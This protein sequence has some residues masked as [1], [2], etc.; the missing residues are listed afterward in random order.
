M[1]IKALVLTTSLTRYVGDYL[2]N[3]IYE[4]IK[5]LKIKGN[6]ELDIV[7]PDTI[8]SIKNEKRDD[9]NIY[10]F[11]YVFPRRLQK[12]AY[13]SGIAINLKNNPL[14][15]LQVPSFGL[16]FLYKSL[17]VYNNHNIIY[18]QLVFAGMI[19]IILR[20]IL[21]KKIPI[22]ITFWGKDVDNLAKH[23]RIYNLLIKEGD[24]FITLSPDMSKD[25]LKIGCDKL[26]VK[27]INIG[28]NLSNFN[29]RKPKKSKKITFLF[30][31]RLI[32]KK[33]I[34]YMIN[35][36]NKILKNNNFEL[37]ILGDGSL[38]DSL[39]LQVKKLNLEKNI[40]FIS[41]RGV[42]DTRKLSLDEF[43]KADIFLLPSVL[44]SDGDKEGTPFVLMEAQA[45]GIPCISSFHAGIPYL[46]LDN[47]TGFLVK[48][49]DV[50]DLSNKMLKLANN[51]NLRLKFSKAGRKHIEE[52]YNQDKQIRKIRKEMEKLITKT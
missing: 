15:Y 48:E 33:G 5:N 35:A 1:K 29:Y 28:I 46:V 18:S 4:S 11:T 14:L 30:I 26:K 10:R 40:T 13:G 49:R 20:K 34:K 32:E 7:A 22:I 36:F 6:V 39:K 44:A 37:R 43:S 9:I 47:K 3:F 8:D 21:N 24:L 2:A 50:N 17:K 27:D 25:L 31:G 52:N 16:S 51:Y 45:M 12:L 38:E 19:G 42:K 41:N 23:K